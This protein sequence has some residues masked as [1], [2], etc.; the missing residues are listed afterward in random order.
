MQTGRP[1]DGKERKNI[2]LGNFLNLECGRLAS[3]FDS[4]ACLTGF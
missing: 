4:E 1:L 3:A 2:G